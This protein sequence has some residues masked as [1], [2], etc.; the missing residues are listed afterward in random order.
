VGHSVGLLGVSRTQRDA[1]G[2]LKVSIHFIVAR[3][4]IA[5]TE[6]DEGEQ[7]GARHI[8]DPFN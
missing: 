2:A 4:A 5:G 3:Q 7:N 1:I 8:S 6:G